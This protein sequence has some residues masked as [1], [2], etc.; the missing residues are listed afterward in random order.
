MLSKTFERLQ[1]PLSIQK[2]AALKFWAFESIKHFQTREDEYQDLFS[3]P[4]RV[5]LRKK[6]SL[7]RHAAGTGPFHWLS[8]LTQSIFY[9]I[10]KNTFLRWWKPPSEGQRYQTDQ[11]PRFP[12]CRQHW[13]Q[14]WQ[15]RPHHCD[16]VS[17]VWMDDHPG[18]DCSAEGRC[19]H[20][21][22]LV[23]GVHFSGS[24]CSTS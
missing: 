6:S 24:S 2:R 18:W 4:H 22:R 9:H 21:P 7:S 8:D 16:W 14:R 15:P 17:S 3:C 5:V 11:V 1:R 12:Q 19:E 10:C 20:T 13:P 23:N